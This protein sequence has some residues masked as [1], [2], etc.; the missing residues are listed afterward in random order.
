MQHAIYAPT[1]KD[2][3][4][5]RRLVELAVAAERAG[6]DGFF[7]WDVLFMEPGAATADSTVAL[8]AIAQA[9]SKI[10]IGTMITPLARRRPWKLAKELATLDQLSGGRVVLGIGLGEPADI[11]F[12]SVGDDATPKGRAERLDEGLAILDPLLRGSTVNHA[13]KHFHL[14]NTQ[15]IPACVQ[16]PRLP[17][18][19]GA[20]LPARAGLR[21]AARWD[22]L[23]PISFP[24]E[25]A[26]RADGS[27]DIAQTWLTPDAFAE[28][29]KST[30][31]YRDTLGLNQADASFDFA[32][33]GDTRDDTAAQ[34]R[35][36]VAAFEAVGATWWLEC[37]D[38]RI[39]T[40]DASL[41][42]IADRQRGV[43]DPYCVS[44]RGPTAPRP[45]AGRARDARRLGNEA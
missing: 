41:A 20:G 13:G 17:I 30:L 39:G 11:E 5:P 12:G 27:Y 22:G 26:M 36:K 37:L 14:R 42:H 15:I 3:A 31:E 43:A 25:P 34:A 18:W 16:R 38:D 2:Y 19:G 7:I 32:A 28:V 9:T 33:T 35:A 45:A 21:R 1:I 8:G 6:F 10:R 23:F 29:V 4:D 44:H 24:A 40:Y